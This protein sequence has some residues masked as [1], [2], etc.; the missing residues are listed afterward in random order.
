MELRVFYD[1]EFQMLRSCVTERT[2]R[3]VARYPK[4]RGHST[5]KLRERWE[6]N[7]DWYVTSINIHNVQDLPVCEIQMNVGRVS[8]CYKQFIIYI[9]IIN[10]EILGVFLHKNMCVQKLQVYS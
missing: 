10:H 2:S 8:K 4:R 1:G 3:V 6:M 5:I 7:S 9:I